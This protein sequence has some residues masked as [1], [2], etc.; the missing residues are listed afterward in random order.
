[1]FAIAALE[2]AAAFDDCDTRSGFFSHGG[3]AFSWASIRN[4]SAS[5]FAVRIQYTHIR[6]RKRDG[7]SRSVRRMSIPSESA[8]PSSVRHW[9][10]AN[11]KRRPVTQ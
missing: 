2:N 3:G 1:M 10:A 5:S 7:D 11:S 6:F 4:R 9:D 8:I